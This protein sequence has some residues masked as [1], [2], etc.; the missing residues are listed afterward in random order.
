MTEGQGRYP[1][2]L[3]ADKISATKIN[4]QNIQVTKYPA[5]KTNCNK[6]KRQNIRRQNTHTI[7]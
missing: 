6:N 7:K 1:S 3:S 4:K 5:D 2:L